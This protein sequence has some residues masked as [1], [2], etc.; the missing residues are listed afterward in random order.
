MIQLKNFTGQAILGLYEEE[1]LKTQAY[2]CEVH[3][4]YRTFKQKSIADYS[5]LEGVIRFIIENGKFFTIEECLDTLRWFFSHSLLPEI[6]LM[7]ELSVK[8][9]KPEI[10]T[11]GTVP[12]VLRSMECAHLPAIEDELTQ[13]SVSKGA[14]FTV[15]Q[16]SAADPLSFQHF[17]K[18]IALVLNGELAWGDQLFTP[19]DC[20]FTREKD[21]QAMQAPDDKSC[22]LLKILLQEEQAGSPLHPKEKYF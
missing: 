7:Q 22:L 14:K 18:E 19:G 13:Q 17:S 4:K 3:A 1:R 5:L 11:S 2:E 21:S 8:I 9:S 10:L 12:S 6:R 16:L 15:I 20:V